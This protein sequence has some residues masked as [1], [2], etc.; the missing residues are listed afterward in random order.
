MA[1]DSVTPGLCKTELARESDSWA[2]H[3][4]LR[5]LA[6]TAE[7]GS[8]TLI[9]AAIGDTGENYKG[10]YLSNCSIDE[11]VLCMGCD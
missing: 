11:Y 9:H 3:L 2:F 6:R 10:E 1:N 8:R 5:V 4:I 7:Q